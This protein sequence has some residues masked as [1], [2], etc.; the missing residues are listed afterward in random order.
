[1][2]SA[3]ISWLEFPSGP[4]NSNMVEEAVLA[5]ALKPELYYNLPL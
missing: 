5:V 2:G 3:K 1:M 4:E